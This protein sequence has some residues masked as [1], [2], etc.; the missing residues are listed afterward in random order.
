[1]ISEETLNSIGRE[2]LQSSNKR[3]C[4]PDNRSQEVVGEIFA[5][6][7][8]KGLSDRNKLYV[9]KN[10]QQNLLGL[11]AIQ[12][13]NILTVVDAIDDLTSEP[14]SAI[15]TGLG[16]F[17]ES[18]KIS[19]APDAK[20]FALFTPRV[21]PIPLRKKVQEELGQMESLG[22]I[23]RSDKPTPWC[24]GMVVVPKKSG[25]VSICVDF[26]PLNECVLRETYPMPKVDD[27]LAQLAGATVFSKLDANSGFWQIPLEESSRELTTFITPFGRCHFNRMPFGISSATEHFQ[28]QMEKILV[29]Q[30]GVLCHMDDV[31]VVG[32]T[33]REHDSRPEDVLRAIQEAGITLNKDKCEFNKQSLTFLGHKIDNQGMSPDP[34]KTIA[35]RTFK[36]PSNRTSEVPWYGQSAWKVHPQS[37]RNI[38]A[39]TRAFKLQEDMAMGPSTR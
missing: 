18:F 21:V 9:V 30:E 11:P 39:N 2:E 8:Y 25:S 14:D 7:S 1:M 6:I 22:V 19:L 26:R 13:L 36:K 34:Q 38:P 37:G 4:G 15:F 31:L 10:L 27:T 28:R 3:L 16:T 17:P 20:P 33:Q 24:S 5:T 32:R 29:G 12:S 35:I 23:S